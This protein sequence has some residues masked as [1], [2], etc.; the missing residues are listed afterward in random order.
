[1]AIL[2]YKL[3][4]CMFSSHALVGGARQCTMSR[5]CFAPLAAPRT[6]RAV[7]VTPGHENELGYV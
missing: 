6:P 5:T 1:M 3:S 2:R 4:T 7:P